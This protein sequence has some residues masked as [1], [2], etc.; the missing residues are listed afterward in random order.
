MNF[1]LR[2]GI[3]IVTEDGGQR[4]ENVGMQECRN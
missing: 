3:K 1:T 2:R 4:T